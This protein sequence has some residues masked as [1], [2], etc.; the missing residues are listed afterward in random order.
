LEAED[1]VFEYLGRQAV[2]IPYR[3]RSRFDGRLGWAA[4]ALVFIGEDEIWSIYRY[5][6]GSVLDTPE[7]AIAKGVR[8]ARQWI[9][10][11]A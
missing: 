7:E 1:A 11:T 5:G 2:V 6:S 9:R 3:V 8:R 10:Q 4:R